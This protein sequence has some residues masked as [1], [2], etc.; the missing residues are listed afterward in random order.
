MRVRVYNTDELPW[1]LA[2]LG[3]DLI[4]ALRA[5]GLSVQAEIRGIRPIIHLDKFR[6]LGEDGKLGKGN[7]RYLKPADWVQAFDWINEWLD[8]RQV[9]AVADTLHYRV[10]IGRHHRITLDD[11]FHR[12]TKLFDLRRTAA[13]KYGKPADYSDAPFT[14]LIATQGPDLRQLL[15][16]KLE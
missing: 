15:R 16:P 12:A 8:D 7:T 5:R 14:T 11:Q 10:R 1:S 3:E 4:A 6:W 13:S 2:Q 9:E